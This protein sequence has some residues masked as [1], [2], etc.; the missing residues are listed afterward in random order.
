MRVS[1]FD[2]NL[3]D[4]HQRQQ[5]GGNTQLQSTTVIKGN[6]YTHRQQDGGK[7]Q[8]H[9]TR[10]HFI[11]FLKPNILC[12]LFYNIY[13]VS[14]SSL[15]IFKTYGVYLLYIYIFYIYYNKQ[16]LVTN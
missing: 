4:G 11:R 16:I 3:D 8:L 13:C 14:A 2:F 6:H 5:D 1:W 12:L 7:R 9:S 10:I 15:Y